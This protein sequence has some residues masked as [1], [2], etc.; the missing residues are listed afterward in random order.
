M[1]LLKGAPAAVKAEKKSNQEAPHSMNHGQHRPYTGKPAALDMTLV[2]R[3][4]G[5]EDIDIFLK[6]EPQKIFA[7]A[8]SLGERSLRELGRELTNGLNTYKETPSFANLKR[9]AT[10]S[11]DVYKVLLAR[12]DKVSAHKWDEL[13]NGSI[14]IRQAVIRIHFQTGFTFPFGLLC[15]SKPSTSN[16]QVLAQKFVG[17][18]FII[19]NSFGLNERRVGMET[20]ISSQQ[21][22]NIAHAVDDNVAGAADEVNYF[23]NISKVVSLTCKSVDDLVAGWNRA[24]TAVIHFSSHH[25][26]DQNRQ[27]YVLTLSG[28]QVFRALIDT[29]KLHRRD[30]R[31]PFVYLNAC[32]TGAVVPGASDNFVHALCPNYAI[33]MLA[34]IHRVGGGDSARFAKHYYQNWIAGNFAVDTLALTKRA[35]I[36]DHKDFTAVTYEFWEIPEVLRLFKEEAP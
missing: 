28:G 26:F 14:D 36:F 31:L 6:S 15:T 18:K 7:N 33:G 23:A 16:Y 3:G 20:F 1:T 24:D 4:H 32:D 13:L 19:I 8:I 5:G 2:S 9:F 34:T 22:C 25:A 11:Y 10:D 17:A 12:A 21:K 30:S 27:Q 29:P 35:F